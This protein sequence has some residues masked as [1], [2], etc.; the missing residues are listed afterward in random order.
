MRLGFEWDPLKA[1]S[2][3]RKHGVAFDEATTAFRDPFS[4][5]I[6]DPDPSY[7]EDRY[8]LV[9]RSDRGRLLVVVHTEREDAVRVISARFAT[10]HERQ[11]YEEGP[12]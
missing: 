7:D 5:S 2:N 4:I 12:P 8:V 10:R 1:A 3:L 9:G 11:T 6:F